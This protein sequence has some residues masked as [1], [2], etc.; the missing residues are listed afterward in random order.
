MIKDIIHFYR[1]ASLEKVKHFYQDLLG[2][3][4]YKDQGKCLIYD[5]HGRGMI[6]FCT[7]F[8]NEKINQSCITIVFSDRSE[9][10]QMHQRLLKKGYPSEKPKV[11]P[12]FNIYHFFI[13]DDNQLK[14]EFQVFL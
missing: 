5:A 7:H 10:D 1:V 8:P 4:L 3:K 11:N 14:I 9:V 6:G 2:L 12:D 13:K